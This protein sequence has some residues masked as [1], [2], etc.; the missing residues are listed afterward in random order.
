MKNEIKLLRRQILAT[1]IARKEA[2][3]KRV[4]ALANLLSQLKNDIETARIE[5]S[6]AEHTLKVAYELQQ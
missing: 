3:T 6:N 1:A 4:D 2:A 5:L